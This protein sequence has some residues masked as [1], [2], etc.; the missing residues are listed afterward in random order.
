MQAASSAAARRA[1]I[2]SRMEVG[3]VYDGLRPSLGFEP[4]LSRAHV[5][6]QA[7]LQLRGSLHDFLNESLDG[8]NLGLRRLQ[9]ELVVD[10]KNQARLHSG[11]I[12]RSIE[13]DHRDLDD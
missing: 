7:D 1:R 2:V 8:G 6:G 4:V 3:K 5:D 12:E 10:L 11:F 9:D 13:P